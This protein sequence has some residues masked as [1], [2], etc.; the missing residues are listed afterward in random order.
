MNT[1]VKL[2]IGAISPCSLHTKPYVWYSVL[3][4]NSS[5]EL[6]EV[7]VGAWMD[8]GAFHC[9]CLS[10]QSCSQF[11]FSSLPF[12]ARHPIAP[13]Y[14]VLG[15][16][17]SL[18]LHFPPSDLSQCPYGLIQ[19]ISIFWNNISL[20]L[21]AGWYLFLLG[22]SWI[23]SL[24]ENLLW[25]LFITLPFL[26]VSTIFVINHKISCLTVLRYFLW[27][28][29][30][31]FNELSASLRQ[32]PCLY[33]FHF[34]SR[35]QLVTK[36]VLKIC[37]IIISLSFSFLSGLCYIIWG[38]TISCFY[39]NFTVT[40]WVLPNTLKENMIQVCLLVI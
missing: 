10:E 25:Q 2:K 37:W 3:M 8:L 20:C 17:S 40:A 6:Q 22:T 24:S 39:S 33:F 27:D 23:L 11:P 4:I 16:L 34:L 1:C 36:Q 5:E 13:A 32:G 18:C 15:F 14:Q 29:L 31:L 7:L 35:H 19:S 38:F 21:L 30:N 26:W 28:W 12:A 9:T